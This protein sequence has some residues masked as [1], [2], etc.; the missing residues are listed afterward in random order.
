MSPCDSSSP[1]DWWDDVRDALAASD[2]DPD[3]LILEVTESSLMRD[4][5][6]TVDRLNRLKRLGVKIAIDDFGTGYSSL[7]YLRQFPVD[8]LKIDRSFVADMSRS[9]DAAALIHTMVELGR[10][11]GLVTLAE[12]IEDEDQLEGLRGERCDQG[13]G[14][15]FSGTG[16]G[17]TDRSSP[18]AHAHTSSARRIGG[19]SSRRLK[20]PRRLEASPESARGSPACRRRV[21]ATQGARS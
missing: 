21:H 20:S 11:L 1:I 6:A 8:L 9:P 14:F 5:A 10:T 12:G 13:Q 16:R 4:T 2:L 3:M 17:I 18:R 19:A 15:I 7:A